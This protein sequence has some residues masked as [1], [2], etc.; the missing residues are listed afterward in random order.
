MKSV[1]YSSYP[2]GYREIPAELIEPTDIP[3]ITLYYDSLLSIDLTSCH[4][5]PASNAPFAP[6][7][8]KAKA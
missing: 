8:A 6:P 5:A 1:A 4:I 3:E 2:Y 7:P